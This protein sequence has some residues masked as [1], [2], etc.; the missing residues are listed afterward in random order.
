MSPKRRPRRPV[1]NV[2]SA[3]D[4]DPKELERMTEEH[5]RR[6]HT[7]A[8]QVG[9][10]PVIDAPLPLLARFV[11]E[12]APEDRHAFLAELVTHLPADAL[13]PLAAALRARL[14]SPAA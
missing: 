11:A 14:D 2:F 6:K 13:A 8:N 5:R 12:L 10:C 1:P 3:G 9:P 4:N 7:A